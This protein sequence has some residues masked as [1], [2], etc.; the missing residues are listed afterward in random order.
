M[1]SKHTGVPSLQIQPEFYKIARKIPGIS[2]KTVGSRH[3]ESAGWV[4]S[5]G[6]FLDQNKILFPTIRLMT[7]ISLTGDSRVQCMLTLGSGVE[8]HS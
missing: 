6:R 7:R 3:T 2:G 8:L 5:R 1:Q 4:N